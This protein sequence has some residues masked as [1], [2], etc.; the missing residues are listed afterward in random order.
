MEICTGSAYFCP[1]IKPFCSAFY[2]LPWRK[3]REIPRNPQK[4]PKEEKDDPEHYSLRKLFS[5]LL[6]PC[7]CN[8]CTN[9]RLPPSTH[10]WKESSSISMRH[11][12]SFY[13]EWF[14]S[15]FPQ[16]MLRLWIFNAL[17]KVHEYT[18]YRAQERTWKEEIW[19]ETSNT[20][21]AKSVGSCFPSNLHRLWYTYIKGD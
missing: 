1:L 11:T 4:V 14:P 5:Q 20:G 16:Y 13:T 8:D 21:F 2:T 10:N 9:S 17:H 19:A 18:H 3:S 7:A 15:A 12:H 6:K